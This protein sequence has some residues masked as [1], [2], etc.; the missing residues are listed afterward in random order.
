MNGGKYPNV[1]NVYTTH[2]QVDPWRPMGVENNINDFSPTVILP[3]EFKVHKTFVKMFD[4]CFIY[5]LQKNH[6]VLTFI[7]S[8]KVICLKHVPVRKKF[9]NLYKD[10]YQIDYK[11]NK[12]ESPFVSS[13]LLV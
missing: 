1:R 9:L 13:L 4:F 11:V 3:R 12:Y 6:I 5:L 2:G 7:Q 10:G 8:L